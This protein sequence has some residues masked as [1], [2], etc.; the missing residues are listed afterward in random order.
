MISAQASGSWLPTLQDQIHHFT[1][2]Q[3][4][5]GSGQTQTTSKNGQGHVQCSLHAQLP[6]SVLP[7]LFERLVAL[8]G[9]IEFDYQ[10]NLWEHE[11]CYRPEAET[12][13]GASRNEDAALRLRANVLSSDGEFVKLHDRK[14]TLCF[15]GAPEPPKPG[16]RKRVTQRVIYES[17]IEG[18]AL[19]YV[20]MLGYI[21]NFELVR[22]GYIFTYN[23]LR[24]TIFRAYALEARHKV[25]TAVPIDA[26]NDS[27]IV[28][29]TSP[30]VHTE[31]V[32]KVAQEL[33]AFAELI[34][35]IV[36]D[37]TVLRNR[38]YY[39]QT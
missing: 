11:I 9:N 22:K 10:Q 7:K 12:P 36:V 4:T 14:W 21:F 20:E 24:I 2:G 15:N 33:H 5:Q 28:Q 19:R 30:F 32:P 26:N 34:K 39:H 25:T 38:I 17:G 35:L 31:G 23:D 1:T 16:D 29:V 37:H 18:D 8:C 3:H 6:N 13:F 27:W